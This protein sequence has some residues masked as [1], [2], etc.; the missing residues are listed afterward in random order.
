MRKLPIAILAAA[1]F[2]ANAFAVTLTGP[3][4]DVDASVNVTAPTSITASWTP[5]T[6]L[7]AGVQSDRTAIGNLSVAN[8]GSN[9]GWAVFTNAGGDS[10]FEGNA[11]HYIFRNTDGTSVK[12]HVSI[13]DYAGVTHGQGTGIGKG[14]S[15]FI[16][17]QHSNVNFLLTGDQQMNAGTYRATLSVS[18]FN[19]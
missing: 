11:S 4:V 17:A 19:N 1:A 2:S 7:V 16:P 14:P 9:D 15:T 3:S 8:L 18:A 12:A 10:V 6:G 5:V 13:S